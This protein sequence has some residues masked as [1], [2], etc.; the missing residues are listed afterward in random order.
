MDWDRRLEMLKRHEGYRAEPYLDTVG[1]WTVGYGRNLED[2]RLTL[3]ETLQLL[4][5]GPTESFYAGLLRHDAE[6]A[7]TVAEMSF[8]N[9]PI[10]S[11][12]RQAVVE[13]MI[14]NLGQGK[15][16]GFRRMREAFICQDYGRASIEMLRSKWA[17][18]VGPRA[19]ELAD[20][21]RSGLWPQPPRSAE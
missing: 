15:F 19:V 13:N 5:E 10:H 21:M 8:P 4:R 11:D 20:M 6:K 12:P 17:T 9:W 3:A 16:L 2:N 1:K 14:F 18:Q 7:R